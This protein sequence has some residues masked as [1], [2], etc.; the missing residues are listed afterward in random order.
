M[1]RWDDG[2]GTGWTS[3][4]DSHVVQTPEGV[5]IITTE[6]GRTAVFKPAADKAG[7]TVKEMFEAPAGTLLKRYPTL[8][9]VAATAAFMAS[10]KAGAM[11][12]TVANLTC[13]ALL[14]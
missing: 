6:D 7:I 11:T 14:D 12:G 1:Y 3:P 9:E 10:D 4:F 13:G 8:D 2:I 5:V